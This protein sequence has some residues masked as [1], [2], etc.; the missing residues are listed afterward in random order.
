MKFLKL[1]AGVEL[2]APPAEHHAQMLAPE[3][4][5]FLATLHREFNPRRLELLAQRKRRQ[6]TLDRGEMPGFL[7]ETAPVGGGKW[8]VLRVPRGSQNPRAESAG[9][10]DRKR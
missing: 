3:A 1:P 10:V 7:P 6:Q 4:L 8:R 9:P 2:L 5:E